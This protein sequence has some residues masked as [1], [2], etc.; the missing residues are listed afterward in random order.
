[1]EYGLT[2]IQEY[3]AN[4][5][6]LMRAAEDARRRRGREGKVGCSIVEYFGG[7]GSEPKEIEDVL[8]LEYRSKLLN[9]KWAGAM[10]S[11][12]SGGAFE[13]SQRMTALLGWGATANF[14]ENF[15]WDQAVETYVEDAE[16]A[17]RLRKSNPEA[18]RNVLRRSIEAARRGMWDADEDKLEMLMELYR[19]MDDKLEGVE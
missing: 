6:A 1:M 19:E 4:T 14:S 2:D 10:V 7:E 16:M 12:G 17:D 13:V 11:Q 5:G 3:Y 9:P 8:K 15:V 18:F